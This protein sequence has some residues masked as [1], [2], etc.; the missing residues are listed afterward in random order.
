MGYYKS[1]GTGY[2]SGY[3]SS[4]GWEDSYFGGYFTV[5]DRY[6][7]VKVNSKIEFKIKDD[8]KS[9]LG[10]WSHEKLVKLFLHRV[11]E[12][13][14][15]KLLIKGITKKE[16]RW[17]NYLGEDRV[18]EFLEIHK[19]S[20]KACIDRIVKT[21][22]EFCN[23]IS[24]FEKT[25]LITSL[26]IPM[27]FEDKTQDELGKLIRVVAAKPKIQDALSGEYKYR[28]AIYMAEDDIPYE[29]NPN[30]SSHAA[31]LSALLDIDY[32]PKSDRVC[33]LR[34]GK[35]DTNKLVEAACGNPNVYYQE[36][37]DQ[38][39]KP[40]S[41]CILGDESGSMGGNKVELQRD[42]IKILWE[43]F[44]QVLPPEKIF[45]YGHTSEEFNSAE[46]LPP[47]KNEDG[48][49]V[50]EDD[51]GDDPDNYYERPIVRVYN[52]PSSLNFEETIEYMTRSNHEN[53]YDGPAIE[54]VYERVRQMTDENIL[55]ISLSDGQPSGEN[56][57]GKPAIADMKKIIE[58]CRRDKFVTAGIGI[59]DSTVAQIYPN[60]VILKNLDQATVA[61]SISRLLNHVVKTEFQ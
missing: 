3:K 27:E 35:L 23:L 32:D 26:R 31:K 52:E 44:R 13:E 30:I 60:H 12:L 18:E 49:D 38:A 47:I 19:D 43:T 1:Y 9:Q 2:T 61:A 36:V 50:D 20:I 57:G 59:M 8:K 34:A 17:K 5:L 45:V 16:E 21:K 6:P 58:R 14:L 28:T 39:T 29:K 22:D 54:V 24:Y 11:S 7:R 40:F 55:F 33:N 42:V 15:E 56:Y 4:W 46:D 51:D 41:V 25:L 37:E 10:S 53:N 48:E